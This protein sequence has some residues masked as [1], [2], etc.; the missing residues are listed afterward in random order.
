MVFEQYRPYRTIQI[1]P[2]YTPDYT[3]NTFFPRW[4]HILMD[5]WLYFAISIFTYYLYI[6]AKT[7]VDQDISNYAEVGHEKEVKDLF[8][9]YYESAT[10]YTFVRF[11]LIA[12]FIKTIHFFYG[13]KWNY[14]LEFVLRCYLSAVLYISFAI[15]VS[16]MLEYNDSTGRFHIKKPNITDYFLQIQFYWNYIFQDM[17]IR[18]L[19]FISAV[20]IYAFVSILTYTMVI[21][22]DTFETFVKNINFTNQTFAFCQN[23]T[24]YDY[25]FSYTKMKQCFWFNDDLLIEYEETIAMILIGFIQSII[26]N[27]FFCWLFSRLSLSGR[28]LVLNENNPYL[29]NYRQTDKYYKDIFDLKKE[30]PEIKSQ[31]FSNERIEEQLEKKDIQERLENFIVEKNECKKQ[32]QLN[33]IKLRFKIA[34]FSNLKAFRYLSPSK[35]YKWLLL[36]FFLLFGSA[37]TI[38]LLSKDSYKPDASFALNES[39]YYT[40]EKRII[41]ICFFLIILLTDELLG[42]F[43]N[44]VPDTYYNEQGCFCSFATYIKVT[45][46][47][48]CMFQVQFFKFIGNYEINI[49]SIWSILCIIKI[50]L[51]TLVKYPEFSRSKCQILLVIYFISNF[52]YDIYHSFEDDKYSLCLSGLDSLTYTTAF[53]LILYIV[54][55]VIKFLQS[56][57]RANIDGFNKSKFGTTSAFLDDMTQNSNNMDLKEMKMIWKER[58]KENSLNVYKF[59]RNKKTQCISICYWIIMTLISQAFCTIVTWIFETIY[60]LDI[61]AWLN[62]A[63][64]FQTKLIREAYKGINLGQT[65]FGKVLNSCQSA[66]LCYNISGMIIQ[67]LAFFVSILEEP[68]KTVLPKDVEIFTDRNFIHICFLVVGFF[69]LIDCIYSYIIYSLIDHITGFFFIIAYSVILL[70]ALIFNHVLKPESVNI[71]QYIILAIYL[72]VSLLLFFLFYIFERAQRKAVIRG[73]IFVFFENNSKLWTRCWNKTFYKIFSCR[74]SKDHKLKYADSWLFGRVF[75]CLY[76]L[77]IVGILIAAAVFEIINE[78]TSFEK[79]SKYRYF[80]RILRW[81]RK[82]EYL[83]TFIFGL[84]ILIPSIRKNV[85]YEFYTNA[86]RTMLCITFATQMGSLVYEL[87]G[88]IYEPTKLHASEIALLNGIFQ[89]IMVIVL[90]IPIL[91]EHHYFPLGRNFLMFSQ[92]Y[93]KLY[94][95]S[96]DLF[97]VN[98]AV[99]NSDIFKNEIGVTLQSYILMCLFSNRMQGNIEYGLKIDYEKECLKANSIG[100]KNHDDSLEE[101]YNQDEKHLENVE[102]IAKDLMDFEQI[103]EEVQVEEALQTTKGAIVLETYKYSM[104]ELLDLTKKLDLN[105]WSMDFDCGSMLENENKKAIIDESKKMEKEMELSDIDRDESV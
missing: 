29:T 91:F 63:L 53:N 80:R 47:A 79:V 23:L 13:S 56:I 4:V 7:N 36:V 68:A 32:I 1:S 39:I 55:E 60:I 9:K 61:V 8:N 96:D 40:V 10:I 51:A 14:K 73:K 25:L 75:T 70:M 85:R 31:D 34:N 6:E 82:Q 52:T 58:F 30:T 3:K 67:V 84:I 74:C 2:K 19:D 57:S 88:F 71:N 21:T 65:K 76:R 49:E 46:V 90:F 45:S 48:L 41:N 94:I 98:S 81:E 87:N 22:E 95:L 17:Q 54:V 26:I 92:F 50:P 64:F 12:L 77:L 62:I 35:V 89:A 42:L 83:I 72:G 101:E 93:I 5:T 24:V 20:L 105:D 59:R 38:M 99:K 43:F 44:F 100:H 86:Y 103:I 66:L 18:Y 102:N 69:T 104:P 11:T 37:T 97:K 78:Y 28:N 15:S 16:N 27:S 33:F